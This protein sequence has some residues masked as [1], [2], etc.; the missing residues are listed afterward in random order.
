MGPFHLCVK[1]VETIVVNSIYFLLSCVLYNLSA[2]I[3]L[4]F[5]KITFIST[6]NNVILT[7]QHPESYVKRHLSRFKFSWELEGN[8]MLNCSTILKLVVSKEPIYP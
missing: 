1:F 7:L 6:G 4:G 8:F 3:E 5:F 2:E